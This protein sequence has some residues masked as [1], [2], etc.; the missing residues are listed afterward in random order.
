MSTKAKVDAAKAKYAQAFLSR[1]NVADQLAVDVKSSCLD[2]KKSEA[3][4]KSQ[5]DAIIEAKE[6]LKIAIIGYDSG[7]TTNLDVLDTQVS[8]SQVEKNLS[9]GIYDYLMAKAQLDRI[10]GRETYSEDS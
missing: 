6:A 7:V 9:E 10:M 3:I 2:M 5:K 8:L 4:I 1:E